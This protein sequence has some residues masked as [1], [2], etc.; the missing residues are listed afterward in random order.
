MNKAGI[1]QGM[2]DIKVEAATGIGIIYVSKIENA[3]F[4][5]D[6]RHV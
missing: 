4:A 6:Q 5:F 2:D 1:D 3:S